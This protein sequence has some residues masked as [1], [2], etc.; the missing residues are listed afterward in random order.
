MTK[1]A[2]YK[3]DEKFEELNTVGNKKYSECRG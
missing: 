1:R 2:K 3:A